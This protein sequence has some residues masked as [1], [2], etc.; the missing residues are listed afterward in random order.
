MPSLCFDDLSLFNAAFEIRFDEAYQLWDR[1]GELWNATLREFPALKRHHVEPN[2]V[3]FTSTTK[4]ERELTIELSR[5]G[6][7]EHDPDRQLKHFAESLDRFAGNAMTL[8]SVDRYQR[9]GLRL[10]FRKEFPTA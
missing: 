5:L 2:R 4:P 7:V 6:F 1:A 9:T 8:L 3:A 10:M